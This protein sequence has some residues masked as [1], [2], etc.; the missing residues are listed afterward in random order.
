MTLEQ[1]HLIAE[2]VAAIAVVASLLYLGLQIR[3]SRIQ[4]QND[5][6][7]LITKE[8][9][10]ITRILA[11]DSEMSRIIPKALAGKRKLHP[12]EHFRFSGYMYY[13]FINFEL[14]FRKWKKKELDDVLWRAY[15][16]AI[17]W[18]LTSPGTQKWW[19]NNLVGGFTQD[20]NN[21]VNNLIEIINNEDL[22]YYDKQIDFMDKAGDKP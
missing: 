21:H 17:R 4:V 15:E 16:E 8:R 10:E 18:W 19:K 14:G 9:G 2:I 5:S 11:E 22:S 12:N 7:D 13:A 3:N 6:M 20:F 1:V